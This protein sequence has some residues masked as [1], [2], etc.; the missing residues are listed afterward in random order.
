MDYNEFEQSGRD[1]NS[2]VL[3]E[4]LQASLIKADEIYKV[5][6]QII[7]VDNSTIATLG[8][9]SASTG[10]AKSKKTF[11]VSALVAAS[12]ANGK[13]LQYR[14][15]LPDGKRKILYVDTEQSR[16]HCHNVMQ[17]ILRLAGLP[18]N[19]NCD[20]L[21]FFGLREYS[22][23]LRLRLIEYA[24]QKNEGYGLVIIDGIR[25]LM[26][27][28][29]N[30]GESVSVINKLMQWSSRYDLHIHCVL[31]LNKG[32]DN[33]RGHIGT[34]LS[35]KAET[36]L[37]ISKSSTVANVSEVRPL[38]I[39]DKEFKP[40]AFRINQDGLPEDAGGYDIDTTQ[41]RPVKIKSTDITDEQHTE[42]LT[43][44]FGDSVISGYENTI[45]ALAKGYATIGFTRGR[46]VLS[47]LLTYLL[48]NRYIVKCGSN[49]YCL[50]G[51]HPG[52][53]LIDAQKE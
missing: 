2:S 51:T 20:N 4:L 48:R 50:P 3:E 24:L 14:A 36:V 32:D 12:L 9:F 38:N 28:I 6:P 19:M 25:D 45:T 35:N 49:D 44:A 31:H 18:D 26:L 7:W 22:P 17:R 42:A 8:N 34:E 27:D 39:R 5:P 16:F 33:V 21:V 53:P 13:V 43:V 30:P 23:N 1:E 37:V 10:K 15:K 40:F 52:L 29:N 41:S 47:K 11:N 46:T